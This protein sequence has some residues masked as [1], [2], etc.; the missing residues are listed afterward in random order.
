[1]MTRIGLQAAGVH[2]N[3]VLDHHAEDVEHR[4]AGDRLGRVEIGR[5]L[6][7]GAGEI[8]GRLALRPIDG[9]LHLDDRA[10]IHLAGK[11]AVLQPVD[12]AA[13]AFGGVVL[14]MAHIGLDGRERELLDHALAVPARP[15]RWR[16]SA[17]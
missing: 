11:F 13:H 14:D 16:R 9:D 15:F 8:D 3:L 12:D 7:R 6:R 10:L 1:M 2:R 17:P 5:L 4:R